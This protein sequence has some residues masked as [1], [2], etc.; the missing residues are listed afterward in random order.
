[1]KK[2]QYT[3]EQPRRERINSGTTTPPKREQISMWAVEAL[4]SFS[5]QTVQKAWRHR[6]FGWF[7]E[8][9]ANVKTLMIR[10]C[11]PHLV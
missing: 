2:K 8:H 6:R 1:L 4:Q 3:T 10:S 11:L 5:Q 9:T 7:P